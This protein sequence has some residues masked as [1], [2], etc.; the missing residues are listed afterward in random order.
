MEA[1]TLSQYASQFMSVTVIAIFMAISPGADFAMITRN[2]LLYRR[3][4]GL[5]SALGVSV[6]IWVHV[7][8]SIA[9]L[10]V[11]IANSPMAYTVIKYCG[12]AY[13]IYMGVTTIMS[14]HT[15]QAATSQGTMNALSAFKTGFLTNA[16]NPKTTVFFLSIFTQVVDRATPVGIQLVYGAIISM[17]HLVWF[18]G[19]ALFLTHPKL[20]RAFNNARHIIEGVVG[21]VLIGFGVKI[22]L[23]G[24]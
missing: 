6:A 13:L 2:S 3:R 11:I 9:G 5:C 15:I 20:L 17:A 10:A 23:L 8:Y 7:G 18:S 1:V 21:V 4:A 19:V 24:S 12:A 22:A 14:R 16:L